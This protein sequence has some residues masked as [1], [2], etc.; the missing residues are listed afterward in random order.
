MNGR[1]FEEVLGNAY[2]CLDL[3][4]DTKEGIIAEMIDG[5]CAAGK[6][7]DRDGALNA[8]L[9]RERSMSTGM[10]NGIALPHGKTKSVDRMVVGFGTKR[11]GMDFASLD[12]LP[13]RIFV[14]TISPLGQTQTYVRYLAEMSRR[15]S[16]AS[17]RDRIL[18]T[19]SPAEIMDILISQ[20]TR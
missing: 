17:V 15:L 11:K 5:M 3:C 2:F 7:K 1:A 14:M 19:S 4:A 12:G 13:A 10:Q 6:L 9:D 8:V 18:N 16:D 20:S